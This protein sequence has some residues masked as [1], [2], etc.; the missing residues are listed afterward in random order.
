MN[1]NNTSVNFTATTANADGTATSLNKLA[2]LSVQSV[3]NP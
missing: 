2:N 3:S 1:L